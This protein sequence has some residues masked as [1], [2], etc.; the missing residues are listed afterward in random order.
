MKMDLSRSFGG[1]DGWPAL[2]ATMHPKGKTLR[3]GEAQG[4]GL[5]LVAMRAVP[6]G[7]RILRR[8]AVGVS[9]SLT[10]RLPGEDDVTRAQK[11]AQ[12]LKWATALLDNSYNGATA[13]MPDVEQ[14]RTECR[15]FTDPKVLA[16][17]SA[18]NID[19]QH[20]V[21]KG[22]YEQLA[23]AQRLEI[24]TFGRILTAEEARRRMK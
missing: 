15:P 8:S 7:D 3:L 23:A 4:K 18:A 5:A 11:E 14:F 12:I 22:M 19:D 2:F 6:I 16:R 21:I 9:P 20:E 24:R 17:L 10:A 1:L 13:N